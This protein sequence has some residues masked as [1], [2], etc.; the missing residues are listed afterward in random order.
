MKNNQNHKVNCLSSLQEIVESLWLD[1][2]WSQT[3]FG[4]GA[5][6]VVLD[7]VAKEVSLKV[8]L[9]ENQIREAIQNKI[10]EYNF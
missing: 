9:P 7:Q 8:N 5:S 10:K 2:D 1:E 6:P 3:N 4:L